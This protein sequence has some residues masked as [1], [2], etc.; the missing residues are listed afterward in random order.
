MKRKILC[1][2]LQGEKE[3]RNLVYPNKY[4]DARLLR[5]NIVVPLVLSVL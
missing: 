4:E 5:V 3:K 2:G 1:I